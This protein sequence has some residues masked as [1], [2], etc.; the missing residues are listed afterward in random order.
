MDRIANVRELIMVSSVT[1]KN[2]KVFLSIIF[3]FFFF[4]SLKVFCGKDLLNAIVRGSFAVREAQVESAGL[5]GTDLGAGVKSKLL[6]N[7]SSRFR[8]STIANKS[9]NQVGRNSADIESKSS[10]PSPVGSIRAATEDADKGVPPAFIVFEQKLFAL[11]LAVNPPLIKW[12][13]FEGLANHSGITK[14]EDL[15]LL[16]GYLQDLGS[17]LFFESES[18]DEKEKEKRSFEMDDMVIL[19]MRWLM[20]GNLPRLFLLL[21]GGKKKCSRVSLAG[22]RALSGKSRRAR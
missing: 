7:I 20:K 8:R 17:I 1:N 10:D 9:S 4:S 12:S 16:A 2:I 19:D 5:G 11:R 6:R 14:R 18:K 15:I 3:V 13:Q 22:I 21:M